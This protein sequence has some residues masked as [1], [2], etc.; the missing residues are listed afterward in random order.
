MSTEWPRPK[1]QLKVSFI[2]RHG[3]LLLSLLLACG[4]QAFYWAYTVEDAYVLYRYVDHFIQGHGLVFNIGERVESFYLLWVLVLSGFAK[5]NFDVLLASKI[6]GG[7]FALLTLIALDRLN[8]VISAREEPPPPCW[9]VLLL[10]CNASFALWSIAGLET[11]FN[12]FVIVITVTL[13]V[14]AC[15]TRKSLYFL[16]SSFCLGL[17]TLIRPEGFIFWGMAFLSYGWICL[18]ERTWPIQKISCLTIPFLIIFL[19]YLLWRFAYYGTLV[20]NSVLLKV[21]LGTSVQ[22][23]RQGLLDL[24]FF[25]KHYTIGVFLFP[26]LLLFTK[27][28]PLGVNLILFFCALYLFAFVAG[29]GGDWMP[30]YRFMVPILPLL[31]LLAGRGIHTLVTLLSDSITDGGRKVL[32]A[33]LLSSLLVMNPALAFFSKYLNNQQARLNEPGVQ[34]VG[35]TAGTYLESFGR[36]L[37]ETADPGDLLAVDGAGAMPYYSGLPTVDLWGFMTPAITKIIIQK[38]RPLQERLREIADYVV[39]LRPKYIQVVEP[40]GEL[41]KKNPYFQKNYKPVPGWEHTPMFQRQ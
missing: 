38:N 23:I 17:L 21:G 27:Q 39:S 12:S 8:R 41:I 19:G 14:K 3:L 40:T 11:A 36:Y 7:V 9:G 4:F 20:P 25:S 22:H 6:L 15:Q 24:Y 28:R 31:F 34:L 10:S 5:L 37:K 35:G 33:L 29:L 16:M 30:L 26:V 18:R 13:F 32:T 2:S 1:A